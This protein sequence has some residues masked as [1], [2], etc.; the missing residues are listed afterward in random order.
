MYPLSAG[1]LLTF[2]E[3]GTKYPVLELI[4]PQVTLNET[5]YAELGPLYVGAQLLWGTFFDYASYTSVLV[6]MGL[7]GYPHLKSTIIKFLERQR[8]TK[9]G[10]KLTVNEQYN[11][12]LNVLMRS[13]EEVP[14]SWFILLFLVSFIIIVT[15]VGTGYLY[16]PLWTYFIA[17][18]TGAIVVIV[19]SRACHHAGKANILSPSDGSTPFPTSN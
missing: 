17:L 15:I 12:Q 16:I 4:T 8:V 7:F 14:L 2:P 13:Y 11:D 5:A 10:K 6:W 18:A 9:E 3:N 19:S 1:F